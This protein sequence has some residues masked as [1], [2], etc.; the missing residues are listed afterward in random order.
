VRRSA[1]VAVVVALLVAGCGGGDKKESASST[2]AQR[3]TPA[4]REPLSVAA[5]RLERLLPDGD[6]KPLAKLMLHSVRRGR[7]VPP[8]RPPNAAECSFI[9]REAAVDLKGF[10][11]SRVREFGPAALVE[12]S[13]A[14]A[15]G[16]SVVGTLW[17]LDVDRSWKLLYNAILRPQIGMKPRPGF[18]TNARAFVGAVAARNCNL[19]WRLLNVGSRFVRGADGDRA[20]F[21]RQFLPAYK[22]KRNG[23]ADLGANPGVRPKLLGATRDIAYFG[24]DLKSGRYLVA[25]LTGRL[26]GIANA[27]QKDHVDPSVLE[28]V[29][30]RRPR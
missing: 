5:K 22:E 29:T 4:P 3:A 13:G 16:G 11:V 23:I 15:G 14:H 7:D 21:C 17:A 1:S 6:C 12:G 28:L 2:P 9:R 18:E 10:K 24:L 27:E 19:I 20:L 26:G 25:A 8:S 30:I